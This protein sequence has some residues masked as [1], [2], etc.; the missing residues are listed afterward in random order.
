MALTNQHQ[1]KIRSYLLGTLPTAEREALEE[2]CFTDKNQY[3]Q[4]CEVENMLI[5]S[6]VRGTLSPSERA[7]FTQNYLPLPQRQERVQTA[8]LLLAEIDAQ[9]HFVPLTMRDRLQ[10]L[11]AFFVKPQF[12]TAVACGCA[13][14]LSFVGW[15]LWQQNK[16]LQREVAALTQASEQQRQN[17]LEQKL[18]QAE[19]V[20]SKF[21]QIAKLGK[22]SKDAQPASTTKSLQI[23]SDHLPPIKVVTLIL[24]N[25]LLRSNEAQDL[26]QLTLAVETKSAEILCDIPR[27]EFKNFVLILQTASGQ[28]VITN[29]STIA[30][31]RKNTQRL[32]MM[33]PAQKINAGD[34]V[35]IVSGTK[36]SGEAEEIRRFPFKVSK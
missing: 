6:Y 3:Y 10:S 28:P 7:L 26:P 9:D 19:T 33:I 12:M 2:F 35:M 27:T 34:Y 14:V 1:E 23:P 20:N 29:K 11:F 8:Q 15:R 30:A 16:N 18:N 13:L 17:A 36:T 22:E 4:L 31:V 25:S 21:D 24:G 32:R 5:D